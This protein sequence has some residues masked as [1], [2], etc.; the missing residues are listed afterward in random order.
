MLHRKNRQNYLKKAGFY[1]AE[2][3]GLL[4]LLATGYMWIVILFALAGP[5]GSL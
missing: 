5:G 2:L 3:M 4:F 1:L